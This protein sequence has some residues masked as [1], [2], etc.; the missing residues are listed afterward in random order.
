[1]GGYFIF[2]IGESAA[3]VKRMAVIMV[4]EWNPVKMILIGEVSVGEHACVKFSCLSFKNG[5]WLKYVFIY[6]S[7]ALWDQQYWHDW[8]RAAPGEYVRY[9]TYFSVFQYRG[10]MFVVEHY[11]NVVCLHVGSVLV[12]DEGYPCLLQYTLF[13]NFMH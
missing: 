7:V 8:R 2:M 5:V 6:I 13:Y 1:M 12:V 10:L 9:F 11:L 4:D 3:V